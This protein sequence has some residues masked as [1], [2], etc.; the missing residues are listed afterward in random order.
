MHIEQ[1]FGATAIGMVGA[2]LVVVAAQ[3]RGDKDDGSGS[4]IVVPAATCTELPATARK[5]N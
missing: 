1:M 2:C 5:R 4:V 3:A